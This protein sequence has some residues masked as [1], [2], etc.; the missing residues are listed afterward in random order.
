MSM[1]VSAMR[2]RVRRS[3]T[4]ERGRGAA[5]LEP[6]SAPLVDLGPGAE[7]D[8]QP[9]PGLLAAGKGDRVLAARRVDSN[10]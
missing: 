6:G 5:D 3:R 8:L 2:S 4:A 7:Q 1:P 9:F 10:R